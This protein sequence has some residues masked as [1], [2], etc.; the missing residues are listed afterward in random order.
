LSQIHSESLL[1]CFEGSP[2][3]ISTFQFRTNPKRVCPEILSFSDF[4]TFADQEFGH[5]TFNCRVVI[6]EDLV[7]TDSSILQC[8]AMGGTS[9]LTEVLKYLADR[10]GSAQESRR[11]TD[12]FGLLEEMR[13]SF[14]ATFTTRISSFFRRFIDQ[15]RTY[16]F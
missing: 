4:V 1:R 5:I 16:V 10:S 6:D 3:Q 8:G 7:V 15:L 14:D 2:F 11:T 12:L 9:E 13:E